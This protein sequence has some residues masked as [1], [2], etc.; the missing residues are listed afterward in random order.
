MRIIRTKQAADM[1][2]VSRATL[3][4]WSRAGGTFPLPFQVGPNAVG[5][6]QDEL[7]QWLES[8]RQ[9]G[10]RTVQQPRGSAEA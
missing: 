9:A 7:R 4:R 2:G 3:W 10:H 5:F 6:D 1:L 8:R